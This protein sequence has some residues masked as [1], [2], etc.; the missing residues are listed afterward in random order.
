LFDQALQ[1]LREEQSNAGREQLFDALKSFIVDDASSGEYNAV[2]ERVQ[3]TP[4]A[5]A[6]TVHRWRERYKKLVYEEIVRTVADSSEI[7]DE[8]HRFFKVM[9]Q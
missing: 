2:A 1:H 9:E 8:L 7:E 4:N 3:M 5:V 6:V